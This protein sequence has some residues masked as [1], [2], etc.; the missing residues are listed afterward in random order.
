MLNRS[1]LRP[2]GAPR[3]HTE[4]I[5]EADNGE[6]ALFTAESALSSMANTFNSTNPLGF[7]KEPRRES[8][9]ISAFRPR[10][11]ELMHPLQ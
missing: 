5:E 7:P 2:S 3:V 11:I 9:A 6:P 1:G 8:G 4:I 10:R